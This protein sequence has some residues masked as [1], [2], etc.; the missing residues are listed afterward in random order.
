MAVKRLLLW[1]GIRKL[2]VKD[3]SVTQFQCISQFNKYIRPV[4]KNLK[5]IR[6]LEIHVSSSFKILLNSYCNTIE[7]LILVGDDFNN[8]EWEVLLSKVRGLKTLDMSSVKRDYL[9]TVD[10]EEGFFSNMAHLFPDLHS[11]ID[12]EPECWLLI[13][14]CS[15]LKHIKLRVVDQ[16]DVNLIADNCPQLEILDVWKDSFAQDEQVVHLATSCQHLTHICLKGDELTDLSIC[17]LAGFQKNNNRRGRC[18]SSCLK[19]FKQIKLAN[20]AT[21]NDLARTR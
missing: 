6:V 11:Y 1:L 4:L 19:S 5:F 18:L 15:V 20:G 10:K 7:S 21:F 14:G 2:K 3:I 16:I 12:H 17:K 8:S 13:K 9:P